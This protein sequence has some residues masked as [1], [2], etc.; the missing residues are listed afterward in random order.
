M[1]GKQILTLALSCLSLSSFAQMNDNKLKFDINKYQTKMLSFNTKSFKVRAFENIVY[2]ANPADTIYQKLNIYI[3]EA[4]F[5]NSS[6]NGYTAANA[7]IFLPNQIGGYMPAKPGST[8]ARKMGMQPPLNGELPKDIPKEILEKIKSGA[9]PDMMGGPKGNT[10]VEA[11]AHGY[12]VASPGARGR[13]NSNGRAPAAIVD[14][15]AAVRYLKYNDKLMPG[16]ANKIVSNG[17]SA[18][19]AMSS[20]LGATGNNMDYEPYLKALGAAPAKDDIFAVSAYCPITN[21]DHADMAYE[22]QFS[23]QNTFEARGPMARAG[24]GANTLTPSQIKLSAELKKGFPEYVNSLKLK[25]DKGSLLTL[26]NNGNG[27]FKELVKTYVIASANTAIEGGKDLKSLTWLTYAGNKVTDL[28]WDKY[29][30]YM[31]RQKTPP[32]F[33]ALDLSTPETEEFGTH[34]INNQHF[35][36]FGLKNSTVKDARI[37]DG[38]IIK[39]MNPMY[40]IGDSK[41]KT[42]KYWRIRHGSKDKDGSLATPVLLGT[43]LKNNGFDVNLELPWDKPHSGDYDLNELF[44]WIDTICK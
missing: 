42:A 23:G 22:W 10:I 20:L 35:T 26:D 9:M 1:V 24:E 34:K 43:L 15:K 7:P 39:M 4:Y 38:K 28:D 32:A 5:N 16:D 11:L 33:D 8:D 21:L 19:G 37:A 13:T 30:A 25:D 44:S 31:Q 6:I 29:V 36:Q 41:T 3:P 12:I 40:Y 14:L 2:V 27:S 17:T 18:G